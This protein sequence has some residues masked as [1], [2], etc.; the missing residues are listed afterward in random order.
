MKSLESIFSK[1]SRSKSVEKKI[2]LYCQSAFFQYEINLH[3][4]EWCDKTGFVILNLHSSFPVQDLDKTL[5]HI[6]HK[7]KY[8]SE[9]VVDKEIQCSMMAHIWVGCNVNK[10]TALNRLRA[11]FCFSPTKYFA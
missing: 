6:I 2:W 5:F 10:V 8:V 7:I 1:F 4:S 9:A 11:N 3:S